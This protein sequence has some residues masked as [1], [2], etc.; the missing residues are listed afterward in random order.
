MLITFLKKVSFKNDELFSYIIKD[1]KLY[2][3]MPNNNILVTKLNVSNIVKQD[4]KECYFI[5][6]DTLYYVHFDESQ[7]KV[8]GKS[9]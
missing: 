5:A 2:Y 4:G 6:G 1:D 8:N 7:I 9:L 3:K